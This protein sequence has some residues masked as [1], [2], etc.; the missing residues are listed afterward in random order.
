MG[1]KGGT[2]LDGWRG[3]A[4]KD[5]TFVS[6]LTAGSGL[7]LTPIYGI[8]AAGTSLTAVIRPDYTGADIYAAPAGYHL[9]P[10]AVTAPKLGHWG[11]AG[12]NS[13]RGPGQFAL[14][15]LAAQGLGLGKPPC[16]QQRFNDAELV[17]LDPQASQALP[18]SGT[19]LTG[20]EGSGRFGEHPR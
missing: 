17:R 16:A 18:P 8:A 13:I 5:W 6:N 20:A 4:I 19:R 14:N 2:L 15:E 11:N 1:M 12:R 3:R 9:N 7:P 10:A